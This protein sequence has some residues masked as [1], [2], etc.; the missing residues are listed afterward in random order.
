M[1]DTIIDNHINEGKS[2]SATQLAVYHNIV[3]IMYWGIHPSDWTQMTH[4]ERVKRILEH[5][6]GEFVTKDTINNYKLK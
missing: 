3:E 1:I 4:E 6:N 5:D 2:A